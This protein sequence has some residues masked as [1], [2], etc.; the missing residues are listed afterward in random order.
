MRKR[1]GREGETERQRQSDGK[2]R[3]EEKKSAK[4]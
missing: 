3:K 4:S 1:T 2:D